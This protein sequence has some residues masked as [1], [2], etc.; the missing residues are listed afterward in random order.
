MQI[1]SKQKV[2][3][4]NIWKKAAWG[5]NMTAAPMQQLVYVRD[6][7]HLN[8]LSCIEGLVLFVF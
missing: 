3:F 5:E 4:P 8:V 2:Q 6:H 7:C 1:L